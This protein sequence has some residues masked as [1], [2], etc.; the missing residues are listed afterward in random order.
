MVV[1]VVY[2]VSTYKKL[3]FWNTAK[4]PLLIHIYL[5]WQNSIPLRYIK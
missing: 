2:I 3:I 1:L 4:E 5:T